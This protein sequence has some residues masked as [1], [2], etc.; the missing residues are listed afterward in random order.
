MPPRAALAIENALGHHLQLVLTEH[1]ESAQQILTDLTNS[2]AGRASIAA[3]SVQRPENQLVFGGEMSIFTYP[4][5]PSEETRGMAPDSVA[6][7]GDPQLLTPAIQSLRERSRQIIT[8]Q[9]IYGLSQREVA[10]R[11]SI[12]EHTV[13]DHLKA[14]FAKVGV[15][16]RGELAARIFAEHYGRPER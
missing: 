11:L 15:S 6:H 2:K 7:A 12:S 14:I 13:E 3:L 5:I 10:A 16:S 1:P 8:P 4:D 9:K